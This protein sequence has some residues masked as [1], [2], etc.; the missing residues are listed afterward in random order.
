MKFKTEKALDTQ[1]LGG[2][3]V[4]L[5]LHLALYTLNPHTAKLKSLFCIE[6]T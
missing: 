2:S 6:S 1:C 5:T 3:F 4:L